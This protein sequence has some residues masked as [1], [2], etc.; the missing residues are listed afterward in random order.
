MST[1][2]YSVQNSNQAVVKTK[3]DSYEKAEEYAKRIAH[4]YDELFIAETAIIASVKSPTP[5][6]VVT[7][8]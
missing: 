7:K 5:D 8:L 3:L 6:A 1:K 2:I 4:D